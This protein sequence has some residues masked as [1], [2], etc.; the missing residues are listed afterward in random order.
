MSEHLREHAEHLKPHEHE[1][2]AEHKGPEVSV[3]SEKHKQHEQLNEAKKAVE[4]HAKAKDDVKVESGTHHNEQ[5]LYVDQHLKN[6]ALDRTL[7]RV[8]R[9]LSA[10]NRVLSKVVHKP[11]VQAVSEAG[12][13]TIARP[14][15]LLLGSF[16]ALL[17]STFVLYMAK[18]YGFRYNFLLFFVFFIG[19]FLIGLIL[20]L[21]IWLIRRR[22]INA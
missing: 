1:P 15:G 11:A 5:P 20:E 6:I 18:H 19:G 22:R 9:H 2:E 21:G 8:R 17:G 12:A 3:E 10:P 4:Q 14:S 7:A 13:K 16:C